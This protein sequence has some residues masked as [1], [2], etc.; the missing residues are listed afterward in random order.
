MEKISFLSLTTRDIYITDIT[1]TQYE[2]TTE[3][4]NEYPSGREQNILSFTYG[5]AKKLVLPESG[6]TVFDIGGASIFFIARGT[7]YITESIVWKKE[8]PSYTICIKFGMKTTSGE[9][10]E[11]SEAERYIM[12]RKFDIALFAELFNDAMC[13]YMPMQADIFKLKSILYKLLGELVHEKQVLEKFGEGFEDIMPA[14]MHLENN[15]N[16]NKTIE[17]L[18]AMCFMS[19]SNF[20][21]RLKKYTGGVCLTDY[22]NKMRVEKAKEL[23]N[24][25]MWTISRISEA[26]GFYDTAYFYKVY[27]KY[28][29]ET[30]VNH[31]KSKSKEEE[32]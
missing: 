28:T 17:E 18:S 30:P 25:S 12:W 32:H 29:G 23:L 3:R 19:G 16:S 20:T 4:R 5:A 11:L 13:A 14:I 24:S 31:K 2:I 26:L 27:K 21:R 6:Q 9:D 8:T 15:L 7:P 10:I 22:R 1:C